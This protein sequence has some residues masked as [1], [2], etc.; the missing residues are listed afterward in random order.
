MR[1][2]IFE[3]DHSLLHI[4]VCQVA[5]L[6]VVVLLEPLQKKLDAE[7]M[8]IWSQSSWWVWLLTPSPGLNPP[9]RGQHPCE[10]KVRLTDIL[11]CFFK[12]KIY[13]QTNVGTAV[14]FHDA[15]VQIKIAD[16]FLIFFFNLHYP[17][18][19]TQAFEGVEYSMTC[20]LLNMNKNYN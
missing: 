16:L 2:L 18:K 13:F 9:H 14:T 12:K 15:H 20:R 17:S 5:A 11:F 4:D 6:S 3:T 10:L 19:E 1:T 8:W 7:R